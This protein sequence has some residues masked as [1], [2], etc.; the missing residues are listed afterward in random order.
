[1]QKNGQTGSYNVTENVTLYAIWLHKPENGYKYDY[2][3]SWEGDWNNQIVVANLSSDS[4]ITT[5]SGS[6][7][8]GV[9]TM[10][11]DRYFKF[12]VSVQN[13][14][15]SWTTLFEGGQ[16]KKFG[17]NYGQDRSGAGNY[18]G[19]LNGYYQ[20]LVLDVYASTSG[21]RR[22]HTLFNDGWDGDLYGKIWYNVTYGIEP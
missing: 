13:V 22:Y 14:N 15:G 19:T 1:M 3:S 17:S 12:R 8:G 2:I 18:S 6:Y 5:I 7:E 9:W 10:W 4:Y 20:K 16:T 21:P 11:R